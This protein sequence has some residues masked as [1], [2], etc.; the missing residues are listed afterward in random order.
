MRFIFVPATFTM[1]VGLTLVLWLQLLSGACALPSATSPSATPTKFSMTLN[2]LM[3]AADG[4][5]WK[6]GILVHTQHG[7]DGS[8]QRKEIRPSPEQWRE[9]RRALDAINVWRWQA[10]YPNPGGVADGLQWV[11]DLTYPDHTLHVEGD[12]NYPDDNGRPVNAAQQTQAFQRLRAAVQA[13]L[14]DSSF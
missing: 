7:R 8:T 5:A 14:G 4:V 1:R 3:G 6:D 2:G 9:F 13:L 12:N 11:L 10:K